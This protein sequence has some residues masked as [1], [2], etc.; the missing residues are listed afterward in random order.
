MVT[1]TAT[2]E[3]DITATSQL[4]PLTLASGILGLLYQ[5][6]TRLSLAGPVHLLQLPSSY[7]HRRVALLASFDSVLM[8][9][10]YASFVCRNVVGEY[11]AGSHRRYQTEA[12]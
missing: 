2:M 3:R 6:N 8:A 12:G 7:S 4:T 5:A 10:T 1:S 9:P 11:I